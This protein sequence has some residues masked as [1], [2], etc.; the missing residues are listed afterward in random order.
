MAL[1][2]IADS[3]DSVRQTLSAFCKM[4]G[5]TCV[6]A[7]SSEAA[8]EAIAS[9]GFDLVLLDPDLPNGSG[10]SV[11]DIVVADAPDAAIVILSADDEWSTS[12]LRRGT[13][14]F[15]VKPFGENEVHI[16]VLNALERRELQ[17]EREALQ[18]EL[19]EKV[20]DRAIAVRQV[21]VEL[22]RARGKSLLAERE[23]WERLQAAVS[24]RDDETGKH[25]ER[26]GW[27][28]QLVAERLDQPNASDLGMAAV[29]HDVGKI[30]IPDLL[31][32]KPAPLTP[33]EKLV[34]QRHA[35]I[36]YRMLSD[37]R[38]AVVSLGAAIALSHHE[39][40]DG[41]GY[42]RG[43]TGDQ[44][45]I[46]A[47]ITSVVDAFDAMTHRRVYRLA[48]PV[49]KALEELTAERGKQFDGNV[50]DAL[51]ASIDDIVV[52]LEEHPDE[53]ETRI[54]VLLVGGEQ[55]F[56]EALIRVLA[57]R[58]DILVVGTAGTI[59]EATRITRQLRPEVVVLDSALPGRTAVEATS[60]IITERPSAKV[61]WLVG[62]ADPATLAEAIQA[63]CV[64]YLQKGESL[65]AVV[66]AIRTVRAGESIM[67]REMLP[68]LLR[69]VTPTR[70]GFGETISD[71][72]R[73]VL[74]LLAEGLSTAE[75]AERLVLSLHT[76]RNHIQRII[77]K[78]HSHSRLEAVTTA[79][80]EGV[81]QMRV[82]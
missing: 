4:G 72:E 29:L 31:L 13:Y 73:E 68:A 37:S 77:G 48:W 80:R 18:R 26:V 82:S 5:H 47:R 35:E 54:R 75:I 22:A 78:L 17:R 9:S 59:E 27:I 51:R 76:V 41:G 38:S 46:E 50:V 14:G 23:T 12:V 43:L 30:G 60:L 44:T 70:R 19:Q 45:P 11:L 36:G 57:G 61:L 2:L 32:L 25:I 69:R 66:D 15:L 21:L 81:V 33:E 58:E 1:L 74:Q 64:G 42:P 49:E 7:E 24:L 28:A 8:K 10:P 56:A 52:V 62:S 71:R 55:M 34:V 53:E 67:P 16:A 3:D 6:V 65:M 20:S 79:V 63:G 39:R 40:W